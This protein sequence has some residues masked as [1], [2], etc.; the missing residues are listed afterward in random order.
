[1]HAL[2]LRP[3]T[4]AAK[5]KNFLVEASEYRK[6]FMFAFDYNIPPGT[7]GLPIDTAVQLFPLILEDRFNH[8]SLWVEFLEGRKHVISRD[9]HA[10]L[11]EFALTISAD[12]NNF[13]ENGAWPVLLDEFVEFARPKLGITASTSEMDDE[14]DDCT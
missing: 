7:K 2:T 12:L 3:M 13:D 14:S 4:F 8:L 9:T 10:M 5:L 1:M 6:F 11:L